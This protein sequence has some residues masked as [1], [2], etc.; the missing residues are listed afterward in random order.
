M[1]HRILISNGHFVFFPAGPRIQLEKGT[2]VSR[3]RLESV[4]AFPDEHLKDLVFGPVPGRVLVSAPFASSSGL[5]ED[6]A[7]AAEVLE[8][9]NTILRSA[10]SFSL[11]CEFVS[12]CKSLYSNKMSP[13]FRSR[14]VNPRI[15]SHIGY[16]DAVD[17]RRPTSRRR[18]NE[19]GKGELQC[20]KPPDWKS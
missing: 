9:N 13:S 6:A 8:Q 15:G 19:F 14:D 10:H 17:A 5:S 4:G 12:F 1:V 20:R 16:G 2:L 3:C 11:S 18:P 7:C